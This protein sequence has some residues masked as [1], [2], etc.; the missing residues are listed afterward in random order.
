MV[1]HPKTKNKVKMVQTETAQGNA[2]SGTTQNIKATPNM[3]EAQKV[4]VKKVHGAAHGA[5]HTGHVH[6]GE[7]HEHHEEKK[8][9][10]R[11]SCS[12]T[13]RNAAI[14]VL[15]LAL[16]AVLIWSFT[17]ERDGKATGNNNVA[18]AGNQVMDAATLQAMTTLASDDAFLGAKDAPVIMVEFS[19]YQCPYCAKF[20]SDAWPK[21]KTNFVDTGVVNFVYRDLPLSFHN[22]AQKAAEASECAN[23]QGKF[24]E[25]QDLLFANQ[26]KLDVN[27]LKKYAAD[28]GLDVAKFDNCLTSGKYATEVSE[29][30]AAAAQFGI[31]GTP[32]F[33]INGQ[34]VSGAQPY[35]KF[36]QIICA[37]VPESEPCKNVEP[38]VAFEVVVVNDKNCAAC[39]VTSIKATTKEL[40]AGA[41][42]KEVDAN[43]AEGKALI[44]KH[45]LVYAPTFL[46]PEVVTTTSTWTSQPQIVGFFDKTADGY[47]LKDAAIGAEW[48][49]SEVERQKFFASLYAKLGIT[50]GDN[51][52]QVDF[53]VMSYCP[54]GNQA[55]ELLKPVFDAL[56]G[57]ADFVP[58]YVIYGQ[59][60]GCYAD[61]DGTQLCSLHGA[62]ELNQ[63][64]RELCVYYDLG[65]QAW[66]DFAIAM[67]SKCTSSNADTCWTDVAKTLGYDTAKIQSCFDTNKIKYA[68]EQYDLGAALGVSGSPTLFFEGQKF[69]GGRTSNDYLSALCAGFDTPPAGCANVIADTG[70]VVPA[71]SC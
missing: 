5:S 57:Q 36:E 71:G 21:I 13:L 20:W 15:V 31:S 63:N 7:H 23:E 2:L 59:G 44:Q 30:A 58:R 43:S 19:D 42:F 47:K 3:K 18:A 52:P 11:F 24:W 46:F 50:A 34:V 29:D 48:F 4:Q 28:L 62:V 65:E 8:T 12:D 26:Q 10:S 60:T 55:E 27:S 61:T 37:L 66:F 39:D 35:E 17:A 25:Y 53:F 1:K 32:G 64:I 45:S 33:V 40:F 6:K 41:T 49:L 68:R 69:N 14:V 54:Y 9:C 51:K 38:P 67:N 70:A 22:N 16:V 56:K